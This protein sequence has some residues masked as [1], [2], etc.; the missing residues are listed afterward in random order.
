MRAMTLI[1]GLALA[2]C[3]EET[4]GPGEVVTG[5]YGGETVSLDLSSSGGQLTISCTSYTLSGPLSLNDNLFFEL[6]AAAGSTVL[7]LRG[8]IDHETISVSIASPTEVDHY[9]L[10]RDR[11]PAGN[12]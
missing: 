5:Q 4:F 2:G 6:T 11:E 10:V 9:F 12:C 1:L 7:G 3:G 8:R